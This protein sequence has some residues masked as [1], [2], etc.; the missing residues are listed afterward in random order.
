[1]TP[2]EW[3]YL[4]S[5]VGYMVLEYWLGKTDK[6]KPGSLGEVLVLAL[7]GAVG[8]MKKPSDK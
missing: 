6:V 2:V 5:A 7:K 8:A 4:A 1:M 3:G